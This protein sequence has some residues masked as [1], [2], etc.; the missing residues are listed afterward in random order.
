[1]M[2]SAKKQKTR[3]ASTDR[4]KAMLMKN[5]VTT[6]MDRC[7]TTRTK[8]TMKTVIR[9]MKKL[10]KATRK[11][12]VE[13]QHLKRVETVLILITPMPTQMEKEQDMLQV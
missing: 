12:T 11:V 10:T 1:M 5:L 8:V 3:K 6:A 2:S 9:R 7:K 4:W 13:V